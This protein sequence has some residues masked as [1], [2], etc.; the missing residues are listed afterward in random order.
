VALDEAGAVSRCALL[1]RRVVHFPDGRDPQLEAAD[2]CHLW[3]AADSPYSGQ[4]SASA[5]IRAVMPMSAHLIG[6]SGRDAREPRQARLAGAVRTA[7]M[8]AMLVTRWPG[9]T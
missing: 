9:M 4:A 8:L 2:T 5:A 1:T 6:R 7:P 3:R